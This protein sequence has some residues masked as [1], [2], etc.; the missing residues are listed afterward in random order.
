M[1]WTLFYRNPYQLLGT[2]CTEA[3][4]MQHAQSMGHSWVGTWPPTAASEST[5]PHHQPPPRPE[6]FLDLDD[7][8]GLDV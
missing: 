8:V 6:E 4:L 3:G 5:R 1:I 2:F 7:R